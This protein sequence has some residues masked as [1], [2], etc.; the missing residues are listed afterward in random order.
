MRKILISTI[1]LSVSL[2]YSCSTTTFQ[3]FYCENKFKEVKQK[4][5]SIPDKFSFAGSAIV[6]GMPVLIRGDFKDQEKLVLSSPF[7]KSVLNIEKE[8]ENMCVKVAGFQSCDRSEILSLVSLY[9]PQAAPLV[10]VNLLKSLVSKK[11][12]LQDNEKIQCESNQLKVIRPDYTLVYEDNDLRKIIYK[13]YIV[14]YGLNNEISV[15]NN[16]KV[17][18]KMNLSNISFEK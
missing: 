18:L 17:L 7:G 4:D 9:M 10:D 1:A 12:N 2:L 16:G 5:N 13:D 11:F 15:I 3:P 6:S 14:D 8:N